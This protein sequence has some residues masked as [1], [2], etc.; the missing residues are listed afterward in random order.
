MQEQKAS[1]LAQKCI[2]SSYG[3]YIGC[4][5]A[6]KV[7]VGSVSNYLK[8]LVRQNSDGFRSEY[9]MFYDTCWKQVGTDK[10]F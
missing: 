8:F 5:R 9:N 10:L 2:K 6:E 7:D 4:F 3:E 1:L